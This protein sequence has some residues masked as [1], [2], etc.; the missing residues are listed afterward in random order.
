MIRKTILGMGIKSGLATI[1]ALESKFKKGEKVSI[2]GDYT[3]LPSCLEY[4]IVDDVLYSE[5]GKIAYILI[6]STTKNIRG[7]YGEYE[8]LSLETIEL[9]KN[10]TPKAAAVLKPLYKENDVVVFKEGGVWCVGYDFSVY[11]VLEYKI[12]V[13]TTK[14]GEKKTVMYR[15]ANLDSSP[16]NDW[17]SES[18]LEKIHP[19]FS[20]G[21]KV[22]RITTV[23]G[24]VGYSAEPMSKIENIRLSP[25]RS[26]MYLL[27]G[28]PY[29]PSVWVDEDML[30]PTDSG[31][32]VKDL[33][34]YK[35]LENDHSDLLAVGRLVRLTDYAILSLYATQPGDLGDN[36][37]QVASIGCR[38]SNILYTIKSAD[39][40]VMEPF[41]VSRGNLIPV[42]LV[43]KKDTTTS[44]TPDDKCPICLKEVS[45]ASENKLT[46]I[47][48]DLYDVIKSATE[49]SN[50][51]EAITK[52]KMESFKGVDSES[53]KD[54][55][56][57]KNPDVLLEKLEKHIKDP[58]LSFSQ[59]EE[60]Y[61]MKSIMEILIGMSG[62]V[63]EKKRNNKPFTPSKIAKEFTANYP[64]HEYYKM[65][66]GKKHS[67]VIRVVDG[68][69]VSIYLA[70]YETEN[71]IRDL[72]SIYKK[73]SDSYKKLVRAVSLGKFLMNK[74][75]ETNQK[76]NNNLT[77]TLK[78]MDFD[79]AIDSRL[80][81]KSSD[82]RIA[83][84]IYIG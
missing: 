74:L 78:D 61:T 24:S 52:K 44:E 76:P 49:L 43:A 13:E 42:K 21:E 64:H 59:K 75:V 15:L 12:A 57:T 32:K 11:K 54:D 26:L 67:S 56:F 47:C 70:V 46:K 23:Y 30:Y 41:T 73:D 50:T 1:S 38:E 69:G 39:T 53:N 68:K 5:S 80:F 18:Q 10:T 79:E 2:I 16:I 71:I 34:T 25:D 63:N 83:M 3:Q 65:I 29:R 36:I 35:D 40:G 81:Y 14:E 17:F 84:P 22:V 6:D 33:K 58:S 9:T 27:A 20:V 60:L 66:S 28:T 55:K 8:L 19:R 62:A 51:E 45:K 37:Y 82:K 48:D 72:D 7:I 31:V 77:Y 4:L